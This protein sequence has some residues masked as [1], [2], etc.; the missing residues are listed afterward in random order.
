LVFSSVATIEVGSGT[1]VLGLLSQD[2]NEKIS[3]EM[4]KIFN[5]MRSLFDRDKFSEK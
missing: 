1:L 2:W 4:R 5:F 3:P